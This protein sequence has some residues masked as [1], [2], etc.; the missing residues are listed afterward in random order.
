MKRWEIAFVIVCCCIIEFSIGHSI[1]RAR[2]EQRWRQIAEAA[3]KNARD[4]I[5][6]A[7][8]FEAQARKA[9]ANTD[10]CMAGW[11]RAVAAGEKLN[12]ALEERR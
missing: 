8:K 12:H 1:G 5:D 10:A 2:G 7:T 4:A 11:E 6:V 3:A 9:Q